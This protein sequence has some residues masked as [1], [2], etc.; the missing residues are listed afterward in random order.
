MHINDLGRQGFGYL[1]YAGLKL[2]RPDDFQDTLKK[3]RAYP[4]AKVQVLRA[5]VIAGEEHIVAASIFSARSCSD[6][7]MVA[8]DPAT[9]LLL[10]ASGERQ[11]KS[12]LEKAGISGKKSDWVVV[13]VS[14][15]RSSL[16]DLHSELLKIGEE[17]DRLIELT[18]DKIPV[19]MDKYG[20]SAAELSIAERL[21]ASRTRALQSLVLERMAIS[22]L[23]R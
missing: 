12:A 9:E 20:I 22:E 23:L 18:D 4:G 16:E 15:S 10:F 11:I 7:R 14:D 6:K 13:A 3:I 1:L 19:L 5:D 17:S 21:N 2:H 8:H